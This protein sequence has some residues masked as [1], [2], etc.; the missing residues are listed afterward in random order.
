MAALGMT[1][2]NNGYKLQLDDFNEL[3]V[4]DGINVVYHTSK[5]SAG[6]VTYTCAPQMADMLMFES[7]SDRLKIQ[8]AIDE[9]GAPAGLPEIHVYSAMLSKVENSGDSTVTVHLSGAMPAFKARVIGNGTIVAG[10]IYANKVEGRIS[11]GNGHIVLSGRAGAVKLS[12]I[13]SGPIEAGNLE[14]KEVKC[15]ML[16]TGTI[17]CYATESLRIL[18]A[19]SGKVYYKGTPEHLTN[20]TIGVKAISVDASQNTEE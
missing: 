8:V 17:D 6:L 10:G 2:Q 7:K 14:A 9:N 12:N 5:D 3:R 15:W 18:G 13:G 20:S 4:V 16:G 1:A 11:T 19:G